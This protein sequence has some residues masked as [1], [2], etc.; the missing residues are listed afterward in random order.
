MWKNGSLDEA[1]YNGNDREKSI[2]ALGNA[3]F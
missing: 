2:R 1:E 3:S